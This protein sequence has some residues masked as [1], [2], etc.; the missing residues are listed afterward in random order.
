MLINSS[1]NDFFYLFGYI[2]VS[3]DSIQYILSLNKIE[4]STFRPILNAYEI[5]SIKRFSTSGIKEPDVAAMLNSKSK[6][7]VTRDSWK[8]D[9]CEPEDFIWEGLRCSN[10]SSDSARITKLFESHTMFAHCLANPLFGVHRCPFSG[11]TRLPSSFDFIN[12]S[13]NALQDVEI[14][15]KV[16]VIVSDW[17]DQLL[18][19]DYENNLGSILTARDRLLKPGGLII[20]SRARKYYTGI[21]ENMNVAHHGEK[22]P[23]GRRIIVK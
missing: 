17:M 19:Y 20:P 12:Y 16:D 4:D 6:Y 21:Q 3:K 8:G 14:N 1:G 2:E 5:Y 11:L 13:H 15:E 9:P 22:Q 18:I 7:E 10:L 23:H